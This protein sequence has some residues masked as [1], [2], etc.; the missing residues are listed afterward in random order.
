MNIIHTLLT[1]VMLVNALEIPEGFIAG[2]S[3]KAG[4]W[5][6]KEYTVLGADGKK[7][8]ETD[9]QGHNHDVKKKAWIATLHI[10][11]IDI[12][13]MLDIFN[14][15]TGIVFSTSFYQRVDWSN[16]NPIFG[17]NGVY[18]ALSTIFI[19]DILNVTFKAR[20]GA[21]VKWHDIR[22]EKWEKV[23]CYK[24]CSLLVALYRTES[25][26]F[27]IGIA[28]YQGVAGIIVDYQR[29]W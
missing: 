10:P 17:Y 29:F 9:D 8:Q 3:L 28:W 15:R 11:N 19:F 23:K 26:A 4:G 27:F 12:G 13:Y 6:G 24:D 2:V 14:V 18:S 5:L 21:G 7:L 1:T 22:Q 20:C 25:S 16:G